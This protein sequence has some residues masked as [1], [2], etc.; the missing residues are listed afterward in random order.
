M[1]SLGALSRLLGRVY[2]GAAVT[3]QSVGHV[4]ILFATCWVT[5]Y[6]AGHLAFDKP[7]CA[8][9]AREHELIAMKSNLI[10]LKVWRSL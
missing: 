7:M 2:T 9:C 6:L 1:L 10:H 4:G 8:V 3:C 5:S